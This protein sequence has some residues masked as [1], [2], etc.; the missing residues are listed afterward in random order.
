MTFM[1]CNPIEKTDFVEKVR[2]GDSLPEFRVTDLVGGNWTGDGL[3]HSGKVVVIL[4]FNPG[5]EDCRKEMPRLSSAYNHLEEVYGEEH[6][7]FI[8]IG[9]ESN[10]TQTMEFVQ[11]FGVRFPMCPQKD[12]KVFELFATLSIPRI[13]I[14]DTE[15]IVRYIHND[16]PLATEED[17]IKEISGLIS[18]SDDSTKGIVLK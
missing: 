15:G 5:C 14:T 17:I 9:R 6:I 12:R 16:N 13:Y 4:F 1:S 3:A 7:Q 10:E 18:V 8:G 2:V 11:K